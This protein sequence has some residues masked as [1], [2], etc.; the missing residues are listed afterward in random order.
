M[1]LNLVL[2][3]QWFDMIS[4][5]EKKE[6][7]RDIKDYWARRLINTRYD[8]EWQAWQ[9][10]VDDMKAPFERHNGP[11]ELMRF[12]EV[13]FRK[14][15]SVF[16]RNGYSKTSPSFTAKIKEIGIGTGKEEWGAEP[17]KFYFV[18]RF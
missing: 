3:K 15:E 7:Y 9:E 14:Y 13:K 5:G 12:F 1:V 16:L 17:G 8:M 10:M 11:E 18:I 2:K 6:E 4:S